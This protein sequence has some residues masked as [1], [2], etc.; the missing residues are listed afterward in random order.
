MPVFEVVLGAIVALGLRYVAKFDWL[1]SATIGGASA[2]GLMLLARRSLHQLRAEREAVARAGQSAKCWVIRAN[3]SLYRKSLFGIPYDWADVVFTFD[4]GVPD[5]D[6]TLATIAQRVAA[7]R[8]GPDASEQERR[9]ASVMSTEIPNPSRTHLPPSL[10][11]G[12]DAYMVAIQVMRELLPEGKL[13]RP[14]VWGAGV[15]SDPAGEVVMV[16]YPRGVEAA[17]GTSQPVT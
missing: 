1:T 7:F 13:T 16:S 3:P 5:L 10:T 8:A 11:D 14:Y 6:Q 4:Q 15:V 12:L 9:V 17:P 2:I